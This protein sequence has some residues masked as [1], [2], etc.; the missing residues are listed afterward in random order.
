MVLARHDDKTVLTMANDYKGE[1]REFAIVVPVP[2]VLERGQI[3]VGD[4]ALIEH[5]DAYSAPRLVE[6]FDPDP[7][8]PR[9]A[10]MC[11]AAIG[12]RG[13]EVASSPPTAPRASASPSRR[14]HGGTSY[15]ILILSARES[16]GLEPGCATMAIACA[17][18]HRGVGQHLKQGMLFLWQGQPHR[19]GQAG[20]SYLRPLQMR[21]RHAKVHAAAPARHAQR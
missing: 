10:P 3:R 7:C 15:D 8:A 20:F 4:R 11:R 12:T 21:L 19:A 17:G 16:S 18:G 9:P 5:L 13:A 2:T 6:Y 1:L 14:I